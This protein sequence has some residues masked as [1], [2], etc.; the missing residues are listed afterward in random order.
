MNTLTLKNE[1]ELAEGCRAGEDAARRELYT[2]YAKQMLA[3]CYRYTGDMDAAHDVLH[4]G[5]IRIFTHFTFRGECSLATWVT[6]VMVSQSIDYLRRKRRFEH[7]VVMEEQ[8]PDWADEES[9]AV[10]AG[11]SLTEEVLMELVAQLPDGC[12]TV[13]NLYVFEEK[14]HKEIARLLGIKEH[15]STSQFHRAKC[16]LIQK[17]KE[18]TKRKDENRQRD[19]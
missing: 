9:A 5:F 12:R 18:Y 19:R 1:V 2:L 15:S 17:I 6:R 4:D 16:L 3:V 7:L 11:D 8:L 10:E 14:S 13:F